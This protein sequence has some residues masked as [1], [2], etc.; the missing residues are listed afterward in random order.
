MRGGQAGHRAHGQAREGAAGTGGCS[1]SPAVSAPL[2]WQQG[3]RPQPTKGRRGLQELPLLIGEQEGEFYP[4]TP[5]KAP[6]GD[7]GCPMRGVP[8][9]GTLQP[10]EP[11]PGPLPPH[12]SMSVV[13][14]PKSVRNAE[15]CEKCLLTAGRVARWRLFFWQNRS[16]QEA[17]ATGAGVGGITTT[18]CRG[19][20][21]VG[22][23]NVGCPRKAG[24][25]RGEAG[26]HTCGVNENG[27]AAGQGGVA[28]SLQIRAGG[29]RS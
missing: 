12:P 29:P 22:A 6:S 14:L 8:Y 15:M 11:L 7:A 3:Y 13:W 25:G 1:Q 2:Q 18:L 16:E 23:N 10:P 21:W 17:E 4:L 24:G 28:A 5:A 20:W 19:S 9:W 27:G 26:K